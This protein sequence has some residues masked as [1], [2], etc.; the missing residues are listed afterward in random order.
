MIPAALGIAAIMLIAGQLAEGNGGPEAQAF[1]AH[2]DGNVEVNGQP[3]SDAVA[4]DVILARSTSRLRIGPD[5][6]VSMQ[7]GAALRYDQAGNNVLVAVQSGDV[8]VAS[9][10]REVADSSRSGR[11]PSARAPSRPSPS[12][13]SAIRSM[14]P[15]AK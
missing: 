13:H 10:A 3:S 4:G 5:V 9:A 2:A 14:Y 1:V 7:P 12:R 8:T 11:R 15:P 6:L